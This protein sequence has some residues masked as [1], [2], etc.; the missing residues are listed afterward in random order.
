DC[1]KCHDTSMGFEIPSIDAISSSLG[2]HGNL[3]QNTTN[4]TI[5]TNVIDKACW[6][7]HGNGD[8]PTTHHE[9][10]PKACNDC[11]RTGHYG[12]IDL[13]DVPHGIGTVCQSCHGPT[14]NVHPLAAR[15]TISDYEILD[16]DI[17]KGESLD[18]SVIASAGWGMNIEAV[19]YFID[20]TGNGTLTGIGMTAQDG[21]FDSNVEY[22]HATIDTTDMEYGSHTIYVRA[23]ERN[24]WGYIKEIPINVTEPNDFNTVL[25]EK[26]I[27]LYI[28]L[29]L[30]TLLPVAIFIIAYY[31]FRR[32]SSHVGL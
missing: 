23:K 27:P 16:N 20:N 13:S 8:E 29:T 32:Y 21:A 19:E 6:A 9:P 15:A 2:V 26:N 17:V 7:C 24:R 14:H 25:P 11:H 28:K 3:N 5:L 12:A 18:L 1:V 22:A 10:Y 31:L 30:F 4:N